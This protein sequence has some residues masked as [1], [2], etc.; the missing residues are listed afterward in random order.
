MAGARYAALG[1]PDEE[2]DGFSRWIS[3]GLTDDEIDAIGPLPRNHGLL[4]AAL[5]DP[6]PFRSDRDVGRSIT[7]D[8]PP[9]PV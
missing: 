7:L 6:E 5:H 4:G 2:G 3:A 9:T 1:V 8:P